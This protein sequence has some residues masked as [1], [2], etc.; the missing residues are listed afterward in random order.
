MLGILR[1]GAGFAAMDIRHQPKQRLQKIVDTVKPKWVVTAGAAIDLVPEVSEGGIVCDQVLQIENS[2]LQGTSEPP[3]SLPS[4]TAFIVFTSGTTGVPKGIII[5]HQNFCSTIQHHARQLKISKQTR[6]YD[7]ASYS[8]DIAVYNSLM[9]LC[10][11]VCLYA[12]SEDE[13]GNDIE[14]SFARLNANWADII[15]SVARLIDPVG[16]KSLR[17]LVLSGEAAGKYL[18]EHWAARVNLIN[19]YGPAEC[20]I[21]TIQEDVTSPQQAAHIDQAVGCTAWIIAPENISLC[22]FNATC[23]VV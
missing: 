2:D 20:Q 13:R 10:I 6:I 8:F 1:A 21:C 9:P 16:V 14:G 12:P 7:F 19:A 22:R 4:D 3:D 18:F 17:T 11:G 5:T 23:E 15:P